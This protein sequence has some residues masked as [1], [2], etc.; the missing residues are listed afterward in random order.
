MLYAFASDIEEW[1][2]AAFGDVVILPPN[3]TT[4]EVGPAVGVCGIYI[5]IYR[6]IHLGLWL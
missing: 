1:R 3:N 4:R 6:H 2:T 5:Y